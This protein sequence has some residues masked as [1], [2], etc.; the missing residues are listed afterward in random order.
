MSLRH[1]LHVVGL[2]LVFVSLAMAISGGVSLIYGDGDTAGIFFSAP[3]E[4]RL[5]A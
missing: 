1:V 5:I 3:G 4:G 2:L